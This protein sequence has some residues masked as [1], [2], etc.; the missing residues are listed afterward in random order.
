MEVISETIDS[1]YD[2]YFTQ[3]PDDKS[4]K[5]I[6]VQWSNVLSY[7]TAIY[8]NVFLAI[9]K[10]TSRTRFTVSPWHPSASLAWSVEP[11][12]AMLNLIYLAAA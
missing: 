10:M 7:F 1:L 6:D 11:D 2:H 9:Y 4:K 3:A 12:G 5:V 8:Y